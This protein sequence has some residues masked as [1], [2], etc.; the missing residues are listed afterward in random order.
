MLK[1]N[2]DLEKYLTQLKMIN[3]VQVEAINQEI[4]IGHGATV[5]IIMSLKPYNY[6]IERAA[7]IYSSIPN[8]IEMQYFIDD[9]FYGN[10]LPSFKLLDI[11]KELLFYSKWLKGSFIKLKLTNTH[12]YSAG[13]LIFQAFPEYMDK[14]IVQQLLLDLGLDYNCQIDLPE[15]R[16]DTSIYTF[17]PNYRCKTCFSGALITYD[18]N[19]NISHLTF[20]DRISYQPNNDTYFWGNNGHDCPLLHYTNKQ[21]ILLA[22]AE[23]KIEAI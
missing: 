5:E 20:Q 19:D 22:I 8:S 7:Y 15:G 3:K 11:K 10:V 16:L 21:Q 2:F 12:R 1:E 4:N 13:N 9:S 23:G 6:S 14:G 17:A 18:V